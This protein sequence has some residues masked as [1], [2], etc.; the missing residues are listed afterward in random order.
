M[1]NIAEIAT[2][3]PEI[4]SFF[5]TTEARV[6][7]DAGS[8][9]ADERTDGGWL[10]SGIELRHHGETM[11]VSDFFGEVETVDE[12]G[13]PVTI[14]GTQVGYEYRLVGEG[15]QGG[16]ADSEEEIIQVMQDFIA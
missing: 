8:H 13:D 5:E 3:A 12:D 4:V 1:R 6:G 10:S 2:H 15:D 7:L 16:S 14:P 9:I 11:H